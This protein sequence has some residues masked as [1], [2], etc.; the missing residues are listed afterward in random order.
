MRQWP[1]N[2]YVPGD[3]K[4]ACDRCGFDYLKSEL[5]LEE[6]SKALVC[7]RCYDPPHPQDEARRR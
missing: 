3:E 5:R 2:R 4:R 1:K 6:R 7:W